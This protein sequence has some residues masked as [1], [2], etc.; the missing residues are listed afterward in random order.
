MPGQSPAN[1]QAPRRPYKPGHY[2]NVNESVIYSLQRQSRNRFA[3]RRNLQ[4]SHQRSS[5]A[6][7]LHCN[8]MAS[9]RRRSPGAESAGNSKHQAHWENL[10]CMVNATFT[11]GSQCAT[12]HSSFLPEAVSIASTLPRPAFPGGEQFT[13]R[14][15]GFH[16][17][18]RLNSAS[19]SRQTDADS[20][21]N[22]LLRVK[23]CTG[24]VICDTRSLKRVKV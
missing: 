15:P 5:P 9:F 6:P 20:P 10:S 23:L 14:K 11:C 24:S 3:F 22:G 8:S 12:L 2:H 19:L 13:S 17:G 1:A 18:Q 4:R 7:G 21:G 16:E